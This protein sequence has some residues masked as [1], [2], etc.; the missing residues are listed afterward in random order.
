M[1]R[2]AGITPLGTVGSGADA[3]LE[4]ARRTLSGD[5]RGAVAPPART[6]EIPS[7]SDVGTA[8][9]SLPLIRP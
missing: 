8:Q 4:V 3:V 9:G 6:A 7:V 2:E 1:V 5:A